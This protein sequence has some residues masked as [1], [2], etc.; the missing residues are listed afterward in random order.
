[1]SKI[2]INYC[3]IANIDTEFF[4]ELEDDCGNKISKK[5]KRTSKETKKQ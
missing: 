5:G 3:G 2:N 1:M 4:N